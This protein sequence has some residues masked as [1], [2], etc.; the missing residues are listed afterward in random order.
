M[1]RDWT[2]ADIAAWVDGAIESPAEA[3]RITR[4]VE[5]DPQ[6]GALAARIRTANRHLR[7]AFDA[8][9][10]EPVPPAIAATLAAAPARAA[11]PARR[12]G[13]LGRWPVAGA[14]MAATIAFAVGLGTG[15]ATRG[16]GDGGPVAGL[17]PQTAAGP[18]AAAL[19]RLPSG[20]VSE[21]GIRPMLTFRA[22]RGRPC[23]EFEAAGAQGGAAGIACRQAGGAWSVEVVVALPPPADGGEGYAPAAGPAGD[24][25][26]AVLDTIGVGSA[27]SPGAEA[28]L[29]ARDWAATRE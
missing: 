11:V 17:G 22:D 15:I 18:I 28:A 14:A 27:L 29:I 25:L 20:A 2:G 24:A 10:H 26:D 23:R 1:T 3:A 21:A 13:P 7:D 19:E 4:I 12:P 9:M 16:T 6:A 8:P 5:T